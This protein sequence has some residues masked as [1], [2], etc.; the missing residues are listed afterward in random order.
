MLEDG[1]LTGVDEQVCVTLKYDDADYG[2]APTLW[3]IPGL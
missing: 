3:G 1:G 2:D